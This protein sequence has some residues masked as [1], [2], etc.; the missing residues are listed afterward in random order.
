MPVDIP[1]LNSLR[2]RLS[3][4]KETVRSNWMTLLA[5]VLTSFLLASPCIG[6]GSTAFTYQG[7]LNA[8]GTPANGSFDFR[9]TFHNTAQG[10]STIAGPLF[11]S[12]ATVT[13]GLFT[14]T[15]DPGSDVFNG[16]PRWLE[17][18]VR[19]SGAGGGY[20]TLSPRQEFTAT[21]YSVFSALPMGPQGPAGPQGLI[22]STGSQGVSG[23]QG[24]PGSST[25]GALASGVSVSSPV[26]GDTSLIS[27]GFQQIASIPA[28][29]WQNG[30]TVSQPS[31]RSRHGTVWTGQEL[32]VWGGTSAGNQLSGSGGSY[33][34]ATDQWT[35][36]S[37]IGAPAARSDHR[38]VW[39]GQEMMVWGGF[40]AN[41]YLNTGGRFQTA[42]QTW[43]SI[44][45]TGAPLARS[46]HVAIWTGNRM[47]VWGGQNAAGLLQ[48]G[49]SY[50]PTSDSWVIFSSINA[51]ES[52]KNTAAVLAGDRM[53]IW[54]GEGGASELN[55]GAQVLLDV[56]GVPLSW[57]SVTLGNAPSGRSGHSAVWT[58][59]RM[60]VW[61]GVRAGNLLADGA[62]YNPINNSWSVLN[63]TSAP[64]ARRGH[65]AVWTGSEMVIW[66]GEAAAGSL[67]AGAAY[68]PVTDTWRSL[69][70]GGSPIARSGAGSVWSGTELLVFGGL[71]NQV[72]VATLE[73]L[74]PQ[75]TWYFYRKP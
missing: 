46:Q 36:I 27:Q 66:G 1:L 48:D 20:T 57:G 16:D 33:R 64:V 62:S 53:L 73:R 6:Q 10:G 35:T 55:S 19:N 38:Q 44:S 13:K 21:P 54:G 71:S 59:S 50:D 68:N 41:G 28:P 72:P 18:G 42:N 56:N 47:F 26:G 29:S 49:G 14:V 40:A 75:P 45:T 70:N 74:N 63:A 69:T 32:L 34:P 3:L 12:S 17:I 43:L 11:E 15:L 2:S 60:I 58:G 4:G 22:G 30:N 39:S 7:R 5:V 9:F 37:T 65:S 52:R 61:G 23:P 25:L 31:A 51:P 8:S 67:A 24:A